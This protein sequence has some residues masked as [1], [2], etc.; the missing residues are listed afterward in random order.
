M[1]GVQHFGLDLE[2]D[3]TTYSGRPA[4]VVEHV[5]F[6]IGGRGMAR[7]ES[8]G[9]LSLA[10][11]RALLASMKDAVAALKAEIAEAVNADD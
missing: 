2:S 5:I 7:V 4:H 3:G 11:A 9:P 8:R 1:R 6:E 10:A